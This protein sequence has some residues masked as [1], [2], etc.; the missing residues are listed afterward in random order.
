MKLSTQ[1][2]DAALDSLSGWKSGA[3]A[4]QKQYEFADFIDAMTFVNRVAELAE[5]VGH[6]P[7]L[8]IRYNKVLVALTTHDE[9]GVT[10]KDVQ[11]AREIEELM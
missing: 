11:V 10:D 9:G 3:D 8:E 4:I 7:D 1:Q 5:E 6:H 2:I